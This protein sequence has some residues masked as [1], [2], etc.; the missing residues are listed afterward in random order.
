MLGYASTAPQRGDSENDQNAIN[1]MYIPIGVLVVG[2][3]LAMVQSM[4]FNVLTLNFQGALAMIGMRLAIDMVLICIGCLA[5]IKLL[6]ISFGAPGPA[7][8]KIAAIALAGPPI[9]QII[10]YLIHDPFGIIGSIIAMAIIWVLFVKLFDM[11]VNDVIMLS[12]IVWVARMWAGYAILA[13]I[14][15]GMGVSFGGMGGPKLGQAAIN[16]DR[17]ARDTLDLGRNVDGKAWL[18]ESTNHLFGN[19]PNTPCLK[20]VNDLI[21]N[22]CKMPQVLHSGGQADELIAE[23]PSD[24]AKRKKIFAATAAFS[25]EFG[26]GAE[27]DEG[28]TFLVMSFYRVR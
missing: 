24:E 7:L 2:L 19:T 21:A 16:S 12:A 17:I 9:G 1:E 20:F 4:H 13:F 26:A 10:S 18:E 8:L 22:G 6:D 5:S 14:L 27:V 23:L 15:S 3:I 25:K 28:Q 11:D